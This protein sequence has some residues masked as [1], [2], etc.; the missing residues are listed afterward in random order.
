MV[1]S[2]ATWGRFDC[3]FVEAIKGV[4]KRVSC[5]SASSLETLYQT[6]SVL[7]KSYCLALLPVVRIHACILVGCCLATKV[8][9]GKLP[10]TGGVWVIIE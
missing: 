2:T 1:T 7:W 8:F 6:L 9:I 10:A 4:S 3:K 5:V